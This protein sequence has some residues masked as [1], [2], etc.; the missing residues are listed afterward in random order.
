MYTLSA[1]APIEIDTTYMHRRACVSPNVSRASRDVPG[2]RGLIFK[3][4]GKRNGNLI[5]AIK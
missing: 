4:V 5:L 3:N 2:P 1:P